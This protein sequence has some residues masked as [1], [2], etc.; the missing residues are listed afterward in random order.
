MLC[1]ACTKNVGPNFQILKSHVTPMARFQECSFLSILNTCKFCKFTVIIWYIIFQKFWTSICKTLSHIARKSANLE[2]QHFNTM[3][4]YRNA[5]LLYTWWRSQ[6]L[7]LLVM[8]L[9]SLLFTLLWSHHLLAWLGTVCW[10]E[11][12]DFTGCGYSFSFPI[13]PASS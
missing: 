4:S 13:F 6:E 10:G 3:M 11:A 9:F 12:K 5:T 7:P 8:R 2:Y 1:K